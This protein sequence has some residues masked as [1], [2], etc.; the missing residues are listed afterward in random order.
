VPGDAATIGEALARTS[1]Q[2]TVLVAQGEHGGGEDFP[3]RLRRGRVVTGAAG[4]GRALL[5]P[6][7][8]GPIVPVLFALDGDA[9]SALVRLT[10]D[11]RDRAD[12]LVRA[13]SGRDERIDSCVLLRAT[14]N[15]VT[16]AAVVNRGGSLRVLN[17]VL[18]GNT[19]GA[20]AVLNG[21]LHVD[22]SIIARNTRYGLYC[23]DRA[24]VTAVCNDVWASGAADFA[25][26]CAAFAGQANNVS[27]DPLFCDEAAHDFRLRPDSPVLALCEETLIGPAGQPC[28]L[29][30]PARENGGDD[31]VGGDGADEESD[32]PPGGV[33]SVAMGAPAVP[34]MFA[35]QGPA[36]NPV[37]ALGRA[38]FALALPRAAHVRAR[39]VSPDGRVA[40]TIV[41]APHSAGHHRLEW[42]RAATRVAAGVYIL[43]VDAG[44]DRASRRVVLLR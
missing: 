33:T 24:R 31:G 18:Y 40:A 6:R 34:E 39:L 36:P 13:D 29:A 4:L 43:I 35:L 7:A 30:Q 3:L 11:G 42:S 32:S 8:D 25:G 27:I 21:G 19:N 26:S 20:L 14:G 17:S 1:P 12:I 44:P 37:P 22:R 23:D 15:Q 16:S 28:H 10:I 38:T 41:D 5:A 2:D 9:A